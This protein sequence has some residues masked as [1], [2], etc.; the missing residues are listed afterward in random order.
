MD[1]PSSKLGCMSPASHLVLRKLFHSHKDV[2]C[3]CAAVA[4]FACCCSFLNTV[5]FF[6]IVVPF[7]LGGGLLTFFVGDCNSR[8]QCFCHRDGQSTPDP[9]TQTGTYG[10]PS[11]G[12]STRSHNMGDPSPDRFH[13][14]RWCYVNL[15]G[16]SIVP[17]GHPK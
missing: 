16:P 12:D 4:P 9:S 10:C 14:F 5:F 7:F 13:W 1:V 17:K 11:R 15:P 2:R 8:G 3:D 6:S